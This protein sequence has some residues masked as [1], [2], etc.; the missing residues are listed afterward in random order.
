MRAVTRSDRPADRPLLRRDADGRE[1]TASSWDSLTE[2][3]IRE[4]Q[5]AGRFDDLAHQGEPL[6]LGDD[7]HAGDMA[8]AHHVL[9]NAGTLPPWIET[10]KQIRGQEARIET[11]LD[12]ARRSGS[13]AP[14]GLGR[15]LEALVTAHDG[16]VA[17][18]ETMAPTARQHRRRLDRHALR[19][20]LA[21]ALSDGR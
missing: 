3:L 19:A 2:R 13:L 5:E 9:R 6:P 14:A 7:V 16:A 15:D 20:R 1:R 21:D 17:R 4:A 10:D 18:L 11:L 8:L 12:R